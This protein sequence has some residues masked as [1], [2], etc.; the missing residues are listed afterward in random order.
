MNIHS[1]LQDH[2]VLQRTQANVSAAAFAGSSSAKGNV[3]ATVRDDDGEIVQGFDRAIV[4]IAGDGVVCGEIAGVPIGGP[5]E[6]MIEIEAS[7][8][9]VEFADVLVGDVWV[10]AGQ[11]NMEGCGAILQALPPHPMVHAFYMDDHWDVARDPVNDLSITV[12]PVHTDLRDGVRPLPLVTRGTGPGPSFGQEMY[13]LTGVPQGLIAS[14]HGGTSMNQWSPELKDQGGHSLYG[15]TVRRVTKNGG[16]VAGILWYQGCSDASPVDASPIYTDRMKAL[17]GAMRRDFGNEALPVAIVQIGTLTDSW[18]DSEG[19]NG[20]RRQ[21]Y[22][23]PDIVPNVTMVTAIDLPLDDIIHLSG[24]GQN[25]LGRRLAKALHALI[26]GIGTAPVKVSGLSLAANSIHEGMDIIVKFSNVENAL[27][28]ADRASGF[29]LVDKT[30]IERRP[31]RVDLAD[32]TATLR[33]CMDLTLLQTLDL[34]Y[35]YGVNPYCNIVD[36][37]DR[38]LPAF[39]PIP[40]ASADVE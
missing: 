8:Y 22:D 4:G 9:S 40:L 27:R 16:R 12:D 28:A 3:L 15:A 29:S 39:G 31:Y 33:T 36:G 26:D 25:R 20:I 37:E 6:I 14:A 18:G 13:R 32:D 5:Y 38:G 10:M 2:M 21:Q 11:S 19:W 7:G 23:L 35:G 24:E 30:G 17:I 34:Y 1:G